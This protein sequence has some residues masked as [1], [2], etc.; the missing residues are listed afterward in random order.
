MRD[1]EWQGGTANRAG[2]S[3]DLQC[4]DPRSVKVAYTIAS[5]PRRPC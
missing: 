3:K 4:R 5:L 2:T 1:A